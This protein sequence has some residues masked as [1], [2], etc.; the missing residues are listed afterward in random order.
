MLLQAVGVVV[1]AIATGVAGFSHG[2]Y[3]TGMVLGQIGYFL[4][5]AAAVAGCAVGLLQGRRWARTPSI[6]VQMIIGG[7]GIY[8]ALPSEQVAPGLALIAVAVVVGTA[9]LTRQSN[10]WINSFPAPFGDD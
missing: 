3:T 8:L 7:V 4:V 9:L 10:E 5:L 1:F 2:E 6:V